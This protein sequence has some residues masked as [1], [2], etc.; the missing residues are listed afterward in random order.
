MNYLKKI[1]LVLTLLI[2]TLS[3]S[4]DDDNTVTNST[5]KYC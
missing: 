1:S 2:T 3:C 5:S 4:S